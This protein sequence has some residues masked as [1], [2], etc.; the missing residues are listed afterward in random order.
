MN[1]RAGNSNTEGIIILV[2]ILAIILITS[3]EISNPIVD[4]TQKSASNSSRETIKK[5]D[6][7]Y[8]KDISLSTGNAPYS[9]QPYEEYITIRNN[10]RE[11]INITNWQLKNGKDERS[12]DFG[13][14]LQ[15]FP[16]DSAIIGQATLFV[17]P[18]GFNKLQD[19]VLKPGETAVLTTGQVGSQLPYKV[20][21][22]KENVCSGYLEN[23]A[24]YK[25]TPPLTR[26]CPRP[27]NEP[28]VVSLDTECRK[29]IESMAS[30]HT[31][32][33]NTLNNEGDICYNCVD[34]KPLPGS[35]VAFIK[36]H[37]N[38]SSCITYHQNDANFSNQT[39]RVFL[40]KGWEMWAQKY[41]TIKLFDS[42][43]QLVNQRSY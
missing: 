22:F 41:E 18:Q 36:N 21:S 12:Y 29:F 6:S 3:R 27:A 38:Y 1:Y 20:I 26:N 34:K 33:F 39:W 16:A 11:L 8:A 28:G 4:S 9:Y 40:G 31:P 7:S 10:G 35:C 17:S 19:I 37:F 13:G 23:L 30:C 2:V 14:T 25:F 5:P 43:G 15:H 24:E 32:E 42:N